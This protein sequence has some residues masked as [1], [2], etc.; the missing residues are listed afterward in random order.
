MNKLISDLLKEDGT[1]SLKRMLSLGLAG[2]V[3][4]HATKMIFGGPIAEGHELLFGE[5]SSLLFALMGLSVAN[6]HKA[7]KSSIPNE[8]D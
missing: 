6:K 5:M 2:L 3:F 4:T 1:W 7:F 8:S